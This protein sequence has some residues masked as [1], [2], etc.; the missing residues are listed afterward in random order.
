MTERK[1][2]IKAKEKN[3]NINSSLM[4]ELDFL[5]GSFT[6]KDKNNV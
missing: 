3:I 5:P 2:R 4:N 1:Q 6:L